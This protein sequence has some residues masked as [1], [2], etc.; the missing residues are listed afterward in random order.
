[1]YFTDCEYHE[2]LALLHCVYQLI[3]SAEGNIDEERDFESISLALKST[4]NLSIHN[5]DKAMSL[6]PHDCF[7]IIEQTSPEAKAEF[8]GIMGKLVNLGTNTR[9]REICAESLY[10]LCHAD[11]VGDLTEQ[12]QS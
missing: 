11:G 8:R 10:K 6:H 5:W 9:L 3:A 1:M 2:K 12:L 4:G 7:K